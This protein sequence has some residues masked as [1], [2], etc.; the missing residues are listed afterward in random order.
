M[1]VDRSPVSAD[2]RKGA[3]GHKYM[4]HT[5]SCCA[6][7]RD[8]CPASV[9]C[10]PGKNADSRVSYILGIRSDIIPVER[11]VHYYSS[12]SGKAPSSLYV[13]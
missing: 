9:S 5:D 7:R 3:D 8:G 4:P 11:M 2:L 6:D 13:A 1:K 10:F 12:G